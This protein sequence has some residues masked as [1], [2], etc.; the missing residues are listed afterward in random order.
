MSA[1]N[2]YRKFTENNISIILS[3]L[4]FTIVYFSPQCN[5]QRKDIQLT[6][7]WL[8]DGKNHGENWQLNGG[9]GKQLQSL[10]LFNK[11]AMRRLFVC[12]YIIDQLVY[13]TLDIAGV[14]KR[15]IMQKVMRNVLVIK[16]YCNVSISTLTKCLRFNQ[17][18]YFSIR[19]VWVF[20]IWF[21][22]HWWEAL[23]LHHRTFMFKATCRR[24]CDVPSLQCSCS[25]DIGA[26]K[27]TDSISFL[28]LSSLSFL[29]LTSL[30]L[31]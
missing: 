27:E 9:T 11:V 30:N 1:L 22:S 15:I 19:M 12:F 6:D 3:C 2:Q 23:S 20:A 24:A 28:F 18:I 16:T 26:I 13:I 10:R 7:K 29:N 25:C 31:Q 14:G 8:F 5:L 4:S 21:L 17:S